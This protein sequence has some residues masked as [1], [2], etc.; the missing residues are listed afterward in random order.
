M[1]IL[2]KNSFCFTAELSAFWTLFESPKSFISYMQIHVGMTQSCES[3]KDVPG[4]VFYRLASNT[5]L[6][7]ALKHVFIPGF[8]CKGFFGF[9]CFD[10]V[11]PV[12]TCSALLAGACVLCCDAADA[13]V[14]SFPHQ[15]ENS[16]RTGICLVPRWAVW[17]LA[18]CQAQ[19][20]LPMNVYCINNHA[21]LRDV[22]LR[23]Q[24][25]DFVWWYKPS[26]VRGL[27]RHT[28]VSNFS[29][30]CSLCLESVQVT[31]VVKALAF[32]DR[33]EA[34]AQPVSRREAWSERP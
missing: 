24:Q 14:A 1:Y 30:F 32:E 15:S 18:R 7:I 19:M 28:G 27:W 21:N 34:G 2:Y 10:F 31:S 13:G 11:F 9:C 5:A 12:S 17:C 16:W 33:L 4:Q 23:G 26:S 22:W 25:G 20:K 6:G 29:V 3:K 8:E